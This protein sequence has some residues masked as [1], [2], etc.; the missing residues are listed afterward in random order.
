MRR[1][2]ARVFLGALAASLAMLPMV[3]SAG[4]AQAVTW[5]R[6]G[7]LDFGIQCGYFWNRGEGVVATGNAQFY[8]MK[9]GQPWRAGLKLPYGSLVNSIR[10]FDGTTLYAPV[11]YLHGLEQLW[12]SK[13]S[14]VT[15]KQVPAT[16]IQNPPAGNN[17]TDVYWDYWT[18]APIMRGTTTARLDSFD[19]VSTS[20]FFGQ[21][22]PPCSTDG[23]RS[24]FVGGLASVG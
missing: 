19:I 16:L 24:W 4:Y 23:G 17:G 9:N 20:D 5:E 21:G 22:P 6:I 13:D 8:Y 2:I 15:W 1:T 10:C 12:Q 3:T 11:L 7:Q 18:N 14:G